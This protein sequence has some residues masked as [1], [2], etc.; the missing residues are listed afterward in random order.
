MTF[1]SF[2]ATG[3]HCKLKASLGYIVSKILC[4]E[5]NKITFYDLGLEDI[6]LNQA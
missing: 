2:E 4:K 6:F 5:T 3:L 1:T